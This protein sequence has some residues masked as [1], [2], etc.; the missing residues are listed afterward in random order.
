[1]TRP[2][3]SLLDDI[4]TYLNDEC[5]PDAYDRAR[6]FDRCETRVDID[7]ERLSIRFL[8]YCR[9]DT[10]GTI[11]RVNDVLDDAEIRL[12]FQFR[13]DDLTGTWSDALAQCTIGP[14]VPD[15]DIPE[16]L[17]WEYNADGGVL[18]ADEWDDD[19]QEYLEALEAGG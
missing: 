12:E 11:Q 5:L 4:E 9:K 1:M 18:K 13:R 7:D 19:D 8:S 6:Y 2:A 3:V 16:V 15:V 17:K 14:Y 10:D